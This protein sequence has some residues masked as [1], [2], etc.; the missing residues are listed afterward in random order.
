MDSMMDTL[1]LAFFGPLPYGTV[2]AIVV[3][4]VWAL[5][6]VRQNRKAGQ[7]GK[8]QSMKDRLIAP[9]HSNS[10]RPTQVQ[11]AEAI[12]E[13]VNGLYD[14]LSE[15]QTALDTFRIKGMY[16]MEMVTI[17]TA[18]IRVKNILIEIENGRF[19][20]SY[21]MAD[22]EHSLNE[23]RRML[24]ALR[25]DAEE[26]KRSHDRVSQEESRRSQGRPWDGPFTEVPMK[27][28]FALATLGMSPETLVG[29]TAEKV[30][31]R[32]RSVMQ[33]AHPDHGGE[34]EW[35]QMLNEA[36]ETVKVYLKRQVVP[37]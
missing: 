19:P 6:K 31:S 25:L 17:D 32:F 5:W 9:R 11:T 24:R 35:A 29:L 7:H 10:S 33:A 14:D 36:R 37:A 12:R 13:L 21:N 34:G 18:S 4:L 30:D 27:V 2:A 20:A 3:A 16:D 26:R 22:S 23:L 1:F 15:I 8:H 28:L